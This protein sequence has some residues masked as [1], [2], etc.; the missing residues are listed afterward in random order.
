MHIP[1]A[2]K[3][4][5]EFTK[6]ISEALDM[7]D[8]HVY[9]DTSFLMWLTMQ[10]TQARRQFRAWAD[11]FM[12]RLHVPLWT[13]HEYY[14]HHAGRTLRSRLNRRSDEFLAALK[15]FREEVSRFSDNALFSG[16]SE[17][18]FMQAVDEVDAGVREVAAGAKAWDYDEA[19]EDVIG[20]M[21][22]RHMAT[23]K[24]FDSMSTL[25]AVGSLRFSHDVP[26]GYLDRSKKDRPKRGSNRFGDLLFWQEIM[27]HA[28]RTK[29]ARVVIMTR[30]RKTDWFLKTAAPEVDGEW[31]RLRAKWQPVPHPHPTLAFEMKIACGSE[32]L[33]LDELY[34]GAYLW[35]YRRVQ[36]ERLAAVAIDVD[37]EKF[38]AVEKKRRL[39]AERARKRSEQATVSMIRALNI[40]TKAAVDPDGPVQAVVNRLDADAHVVEEFAALIGPDDFVGLDLDQLACCCRSMHDRAAAGPGPARA[41]VTNLLDRLDEF[42]ADRAAAVFAG[43]IMSIYFDGPLPRIR[44]RS[45]LLQDLFDWQRD[46]AVQFVLKALRFKLNKV[47][48]AVLYVPDPKAPEATVKFLSDTEQQ[49]TPVLLEQVY[50][51]GEALLTDGL[52]QEE[53]LLRTVLG[54]NQADLKQIANVVSEHFGLPIDQLQIEGGDEADLRSIPEF[55]GFREFDR[56]GSDE[57][58]D[59]EFPP[60]GEDDE[61]DTQEADYDEDDHDEEDDE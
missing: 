48:S 4:P 32:L 23:A 40:M 31:Q 37:P 22:E 28:S 30:D 47:N 53:L 36:Y 20:W 55:M 12:D 2:L 13:K 50:Y 27:E 61:A 15:S 18:A 14:R 6:Q 16:R 17:A 39:A 45:P 57:V 5:E 21:N 56:F 10:G 52:L 7:E 49:Q 26:P 44:P 51:A 54:K 1:I 3:N 8:T 34:F 58:P 38:K 43:L 9:I 60:P 33:L 11:D 24:A 29:A 46:G 59:E 42:P 19:S 35:K 25:G 41:A